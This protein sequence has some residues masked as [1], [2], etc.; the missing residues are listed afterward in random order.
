M[1][2]IYRM[3][4]LLKYLYTIK[5]SCL[6]STKSLDNFI[7]AMIPHAAF[8]KNQHNYPPMK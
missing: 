8:A 2:V 7:R 5:L 3:Q 4:E 1:I 6:F